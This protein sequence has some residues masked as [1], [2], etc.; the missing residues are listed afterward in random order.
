MN[1]FHISAACVKSETWWEVFLVQ[2]VLSVSL[3]DF[4]FLPNFACLR[5][6]SLVM[7]NLDI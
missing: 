7:S 4:F 2:P 5:V 1:V 3:R 6:V